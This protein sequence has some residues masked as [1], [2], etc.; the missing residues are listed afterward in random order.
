[1][2]KKSSKKAVR[3]GR[4]FVNAG[5][6]LKKLRKVK[7]SS[8]TY[9][10]LAKREAAIKRAGGRDPQRNGPKRCPHSLQDKDRQEG[11]HLLARSVQRQE[12][13]YHKSS[14]SEA[15]GG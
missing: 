7:L 10:T 4:R 14:L 15:L 6:R 9:N 1:M 12:E 13:A 8:K 2:A 3:S 11:Q 5:K